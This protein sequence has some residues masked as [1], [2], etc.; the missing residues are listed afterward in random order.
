MMAT[1]HDSAGHNFFPQFSSP[2]NLASACRPVCRPP[3]IPG[4]CGKGAGGVAG[5]PA[6]DRYVVIVSYLHL[7]LHSHW[8]EQATPQRPDVRSGGHK[9]AHLLSF[10]RATAAGPAQPNI[11]WLSGTLRQAPRPVQPYLSHFSASFAL[12]VESE[13]RLGQ[14]KPPARVRHR[15]LQYDTC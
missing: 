2:K 14:W 5:S 1:V 3:L 12:A 4:E 10:R 7:Q 11:S 15:C 6:Y 9:T 13:L 8:P